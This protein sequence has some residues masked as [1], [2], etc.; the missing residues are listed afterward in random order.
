MAGQYKILSTKGVRKLVKAA[1]LGLLLILV[2]TLAADCGGGDGEKKLTI[3]DIGW[4][5][6]TTLANVTR[7]L[8]EEQLGYQEVEIRITDLD[9][10]YDGVAEGN[11]DSFQDVWLPN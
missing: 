2:S 4:T 7:V 8:L 11:L 9:S 3:A 1:C 10:V 5:E 6:Y